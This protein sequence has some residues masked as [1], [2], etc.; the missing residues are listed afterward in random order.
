METKGSSIILA[1]DS[2][3]KGIVFDAPRKRYVRANKEGFAGFIKNTMNATLEQVSRLGWL[4]T[5]VKAAIETRIFKKEPKQR[6]DKT[7]NEEKSILVLEVGGND[8]D[9]NWDEIAKDPYAEH[10]PK[11]TLPV[12]TDTLKQIVSEARE[13][14]IEPVLVN[15]PPVDADRYFAFFT[16]GDEEKAKNVLKWLGQVGRIYWWHERYNAALEYVAEITSTAMINVR[17]AFLNTPDYREYICEDGI[18]P[19]EEGQKLI[20]DAAMDFVKRRA[21]GLLLVNA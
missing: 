12:Y 1:G 17:H 7:E 11:T 10:L 5:D 19:N 13:N 21:P 3:A 16:A 18:H 9:F 8:S 20:F 6:L 15:L 14:D 2:I 4:V